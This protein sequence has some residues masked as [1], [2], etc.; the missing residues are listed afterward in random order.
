MQSANDAPERDPKIVTVEGSND[1]TVTDFT[2]GNWELIC[3]WTT[4]PGLTARFQ[5]QKF[6]FPNQKVLQT[7][8]LDGARP[9][10]QH[11]LHAD[12][13][14]GAAGRDRAA[15]LHE[16]RV[17]GPAVNTP[18]LAGS[19]ATFYITVN[20]PWPL[21]WYRNGRPFRAP[22]RRPTPPMA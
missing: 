4:P 19:Q 9:S 22:P 1:D 12:R 15:G 7:L 6:Y 20:G 21:Q 17:P 14:G 18:V 13:R 5:T 10:R 2:S 8:P 11:L 16:D 3:A